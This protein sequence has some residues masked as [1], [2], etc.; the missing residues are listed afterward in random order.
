MSWTKVEKGK[1]AYTKVDKSD[2]KESWFKQGWFTNWFSG[3]L[4][5]FRKVEKEKGTC[6]K[7]IKE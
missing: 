4:I 6:T 5:L 3:I 2:N 1:G 7:V